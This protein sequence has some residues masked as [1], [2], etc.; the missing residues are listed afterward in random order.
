MPERLAGSVSFWT[1][2]YD[3]P[4]HGSYD[5]ATMDGTRKFKNAFQAAWGNKPAK[6]IR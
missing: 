4:V 1:L 2:R 3:H 5:L 6:V